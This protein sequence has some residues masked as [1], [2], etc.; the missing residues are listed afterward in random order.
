M[1]LIYLV[2]HG[3]ASFFNS[4]Y[5]KLTELGIQQSKI[6]GRAL[7]ER[8]LYASLFASGSL[9]RHQETANHCLNELGVKDEPAISNNWNEYDH[10]ELLSKFNPEYANFS[11]LNNDIRSHP[12]PL[13][14]LQ[15]ILNQ[16]ISDWMDNKHD[17]SLSWQD[18]KENAWIELENIAASLSS[19]ENALVFTSGG[20]ISAIVMKAMKLQ[21]EQFID[22]QNRII[23]TSITKILVGK[24]GLSVSTYNDYSHLEHDFGLVTYR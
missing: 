13:K 23:N 16:S 6:V 8:K 12:A 7:E 17:Y 11:K 19:R 20:P 5:D 3:Q 22:L 21:D 14:K 9:Y 24:S 2:R 18:F 10:I 15:D 1:A 4:D